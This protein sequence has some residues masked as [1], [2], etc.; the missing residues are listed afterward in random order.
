MVVDP[1]NNNQVLFTVPSSQ[2]LKE[3][4]GL[5]PEPYLQTFDVATQHSVSRQAL[6]RN[7]A[8][9]PNMAPDGKRIKEPNVLFMQVSKDGRWLATIDEWIPPRSDMDYLDEGIAEFN[10]QERFFRREIYLKFWR[11]DEKNAQWALESRIDNPHFD[12][13]VGANTG[14]QD[15]VADPSSTG[16]A[17]VGEDQIVRIWKPK[18]RTKGGVVLRKAADKGEGLVSWYAKHEIHAHCGLRIAESS[19]NR[20]P[21]EVP[22]N[23]RLSFSLDGSVLAASVSDEEYGVIHIIN[24]STG[25]IQCSIN[26][27]AVSQL[28]ILGRH[29]IV[30]GES[31]AVWDLVSLEM[32]QCI[33][34]SRIIGT[35]DASLVRFA[36]NSE[37]N[38][39]AVACPRLSGD[40]QRIGSTI[41]IFDPSNAKPLWESTHSNSILAL[42]STNS[43][44][45]YVALDSTSTLTVV[46]RDVGVL[47]LPTPPPEVAPQIARQGQQMLEDEEEIEER[48][49]EGTGAGALDTLA[50]GDDVFVSENDKPVVTPEQLQ[51]VF[52]VAPSHAQ[53]PVQDLFHAVV[54]L[55]ARKPRVPQTSS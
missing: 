51:Q 25:G 46:S 39:F 40:N 16:F 19:S 12:E 21:W 48:G 53:P 18:T 9:D 6:T 30:V 2:P 44:K 41:S 3:K 37:S 5:R 15:L 34:L 13:A 26:A 23:L 27:S 11:W 55:Y 14:V 36:I 24:A 29:L 1:K 31:V 17:T 10:E 4:A 52:E 49:E 42:A 7:N 50:M 22:Q 32:S 47:Q 8:T 45:G 43:N 35:L 28:G 54:R 33:P 20:F 38:T